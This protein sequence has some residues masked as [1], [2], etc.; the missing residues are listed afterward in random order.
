MSNGAGDERPA[1][2]G[3]PVEDA[4][5]AVVDADDDLD[6]ATARAA[7]QSV[8]TDDGVVSPAAAADAVG[9]TA[10]VVSTP[11]TRAELAAIALSDASD[12]AH[13]E[14]LAAV[15]AR[16][17]GFESRLDSTESRIEALA[18]DLETLVEHDVEDADLV[19]V[20]QQIQ[21]IRA[22]ANDLQR[23]ADE[24]QMDLEE[25][26]E[27]LEGPAVRAAEMEADVDAIV[28]DVATRGQATVAA[29]NARF[30]AEDGRLLLAVK[31]RSEDATAEPG[32]V[33]EAALDELRETY[34]ILETQRLDRFH[35]DPLGVVAT[36]R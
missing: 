4:V 25:F 14:D 21:Q 18:A 28:Q 15:A 23:A 19:A 27:W 34:E 17:D 29:R 33:F 9:E 26:E 7:L 3:L 11:E 2:A 22:D 12:A 5:D 16:L 35:E 30:L 10:M 1:V 13:S 36:P 20:G 6:T 32:D 31:A 8:A 24:L